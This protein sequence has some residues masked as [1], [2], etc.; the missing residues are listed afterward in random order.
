ME[1]IHQELE[2]ENVTLSE[3]NEKIQRKLISLQ[4]KNKRSK[5]DLNVS[6]KGNSRTK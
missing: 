4:L 1:R 2:D 3:K 6:K 5:V